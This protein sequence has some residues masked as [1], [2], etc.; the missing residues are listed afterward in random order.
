[1]PLRNTVLFPEQVIPI[2]VGRERTLKMLE[3]LGE[4]EVEIAVISQ[5]ESSVEN[6]EPN[7]LYSWGIRARI[8]R[9][10]PI[11]DGSK[12]VI[13]QG[14]NR[15]R[16]LNIESSEPYYTAEIEDIIEPKIDTKDIEIIAVTDN[17]KNVFKRF[18]DLSRNITEDQLI[19]VTK[20]KEPS[21][22]TDRIASL[23]HI[24]NEE[25]EDILETLEIRE[26]IKKITDFLQREVQRMEVSNKIQS[27]VQDEIHKGQRE[28][29]LREQMK[30][31]QRELG[32]DEQSG[33]IQELADKIKKAKLPKSAKKIAEK[34]LKR[35][36]QIP[37]HSPE[38]TVSRT[39]LTLL[40]ELPWKKSSVDRLDISK[41]RK[42]LDDDHYGLD[43][44]K[45]RILEYLAVRKL[46]LKQDKT[47]SVK[48]PILCFAG[49]PGTGKTSL[50]RS[51]ARAMGR[52]FVRISLGGIRD[53]AEIRGHRRTYI[54]AMAGR[55]VEGIK[56]AGTNNPVFVL[57]EID[58][59]GMDF[60]GDPSSALLEVL[61]PEQNGTFVDHYLDTEFDLS[62]VM[63]IA[64]ANVVHQIPRPLL[65][66]ME[67]LDFQGYIQ[68]E[69]LNIAKRYL[70]P[71]QIKEHGLTEDDVRFSDE[72]I[73]EII[74][75]YT[76]ESGVRNLE[77]EI[78]NVCRKMA[79][80]KVDQTVK[81]IQ[82]DVDSELLKEFLGAQ[83]YF[84][85][86]AERSNRPGIVMGLAWTPV[87]GDILFIEASKIAGKGK[88]SLTGQL[89]DVMKESAQAAMSFIRSNAE[90]YDLDS[91]LF[92]KTDFHVHVPAG[93]IPK[94][95]P[96]AGIALFTAILSL[97]TNKKVKDQLAMTGEISLRGSV[98]PVGGIKEK[99]IAAHRSGLRVA[100]LPERNKKDFEEIPE[101]VRQDMEFH[102]VKDMKEIAKIAFE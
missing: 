60:R 89:G 84:S 78:A 2:Y 47:A 5:M 19:M 20:I 101:Q 33:D 83:K 75:K 86:I 53:E 14:I 16:I 61:D 41:A 38:H 3:N 73:Y 68:E 67:L 34:E 48:G 42:I 6:P 24:K 22:L 7:D 13:V 52:E 55:I 71:K 98:L 97:V 77:R 8:L 90:N 70:V 57:D 64:T 51:I 26:R 11:P 49:P 92:E 37:P 27:D 58:K 62:K 43:K 21:L 23:L 36:G 96:S 30:A 28:Y 4:G 81:N 95:G 69:K 12:S 1:M 66:R 17:L 65:D 31:I 59:L 40:S 29:F 63:F 32:E 79:R 18:T 80:E 82:K 85:E 10:F 45:E 91:E 76:R 56:K 39:Y 99:V 44:V 54:G 102:F 50:G 25:K 74:D 15:I 93:A 88:L 100:I 46:K 72:M 35:L 87:G 9:V 94:D